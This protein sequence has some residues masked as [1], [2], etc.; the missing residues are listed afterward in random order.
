L[1]A[2][3]KY[4]L[5]IVEPFI[6]AQ[7]HPTKNGDLLPENFLPKSHKKIWWKCDKEDDHEWESRISDRTIGRG[8]RYCAG[9]RKL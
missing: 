2:H 1:K 7:W 3:K 4:N 8:C 6:A 5:F 9:K